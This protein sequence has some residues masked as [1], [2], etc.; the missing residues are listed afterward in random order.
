MA[1]GQKRMVLCVVPG[2]LPLVKLNFAVGE[3]SMEGRWQT[4]IF[5]NVGCGG[6]VG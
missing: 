6:A 2:A 3:Q 1:V 4:K 5:A